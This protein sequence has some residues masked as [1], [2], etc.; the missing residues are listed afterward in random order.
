VLLHKLVRVLEAREALG[1]HL[2]LHDHLGQVHRVLGNLAQGAAH[3]W[4]EGCRQYMHTHT[5]SKESNA[6]SVQ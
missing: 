5:A 2:Y 6:K 1:K 3:L 4:V